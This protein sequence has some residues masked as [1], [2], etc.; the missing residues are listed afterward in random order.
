MNR[1]ERRE[2]LRRV[3]RE[4]T[5]DANDRA[6]ARLLVAAADRDGNVTDPV[7]LDLLGIGSVRL[8]VEP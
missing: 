3:E 7:L 4:P 8:V 2:W 1:K 6:L 5:L